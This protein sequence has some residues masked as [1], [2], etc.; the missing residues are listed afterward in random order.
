MLRRSGIS[1]GLAV[2]LLLGGLTIWGFAQDRNPRPANPPAAAAPLPDAVQDAQ[3]P[4]AVPRER[5]E[6]QLGDQD[7]PENFAASNAP[8][9][10]TA[11]ENQ[12]EKGQVN[13]F[14]FYR[15][16]LNASRPMQSPDE[17]VKQDMA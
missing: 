1:T 4:R 3:T 11:F 10:S 14:E 6:Q 13:G 17:I 2:A 16:P 7:K 15:D 9:S 12:P 5:P 8:P